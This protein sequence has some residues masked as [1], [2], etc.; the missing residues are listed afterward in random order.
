[1][2]S[3]SHI[4]C[5]GIILP[6]LPA[7]KMFMHKY[8]SHVVHRI[9]QSIHDNWKTQS[10]HVDSYGVLAKSFKNGKRGNSCVWYLYSE[11]NREG[12]D[13]PV[14]LHS[15]TRTFSTPSHIA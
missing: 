6:T 7:S 9:F 5:H 11:M 4:T 1:M 12:S 2:E 13:K 14:H 15:L 10:A 8:V 3:Q